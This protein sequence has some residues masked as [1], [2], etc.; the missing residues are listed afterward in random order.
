MAVPTPDL[1][2]IKKRLSPRILEIP[3]VSGV[4][5]PQGKLTVY[6]KE[7]SEQARRKVAEL[8]GAES[9]GIVY[10]FLVTGAFSAQQPS[11]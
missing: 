1:R 8:V 3:G 10:S 11:P 6:L 9:P 4:G 7:E 5:I 2:E